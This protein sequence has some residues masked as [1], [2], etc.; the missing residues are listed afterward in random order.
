M[1]LVL[2]HPPQKLRQTEKSN[3]QT[4]PF[5]FTESGRT[6]LSVDLLESSDEAMNSPVTRA[7]VQVVVS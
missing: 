6:L 2:C 5:K 4:L 3:V 1:L 7:N